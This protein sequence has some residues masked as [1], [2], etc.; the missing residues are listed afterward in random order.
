MSIIAGAS[1]AQGSETSSALVAKYFRAFGDPTRL[2]ILQ[3]LLR[4]ERSVGELVGE[5]AV[6]QSRVSNHLACLRWCGLVTTRN[7]GKRVYYTLADPRVRE[8]IR[9]A[10]SMVA[11]HG[12]H[13]ASCAIIEE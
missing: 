3:L 5:L 12:E 8:M 4:G 10:Q 7:D 2:H 6:A 13:L 1:Y 9:L 11:L